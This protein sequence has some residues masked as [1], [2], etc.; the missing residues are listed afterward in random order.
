[1]SCNHRTNEKIE[2]GKSSIEWHKDE[3][4]QYYCYGFGHDNGE[5]LETCQNCRQNVIYAQYDLEA[6]KRRVT[7]C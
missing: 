3:K 2:R 7:E 6:W 1:M 4:P 5:L